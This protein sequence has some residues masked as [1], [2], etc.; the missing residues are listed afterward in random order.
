MS[1]ATMPGNIPVP[2]NEKL[3]EPDLYCGAE[4]NRPTTTVPDTTT[5]NPELVHEMVST[6]R[7]THGTAHAILAALDLH[8][9]AE[10]YERDCNIAQLFWL[11]AEEL[12]K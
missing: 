8:S 6:L 4:R 3:N 2:E 11:V 12:C 9:E 1:T 5:I 7:D 10:R